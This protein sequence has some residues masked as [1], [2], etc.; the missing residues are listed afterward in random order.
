MFMRFIMPVVWL[1]AKILAM[2]NRI[3]IVFKVNK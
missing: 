2:E 1:L 3:F